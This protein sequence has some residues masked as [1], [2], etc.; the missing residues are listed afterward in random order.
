[1]LS[2]IENENIKNELEDVFDYADIS[3]VGDFFL[4][5]LG[6]EIDWRI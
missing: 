2:Q 3:E 1:M 5:D 4:N 6:R